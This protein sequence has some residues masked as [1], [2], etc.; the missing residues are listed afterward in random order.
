VHIACGCPSGRDTLTSAC[1]HE[2][3]IKEN[4]EKKEFLQQEQED[5]MFLHLPLQRH[6][7]IEQKSQSP[8]SF[9]RLEWKSIPTKTGSQFTIDY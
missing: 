8:S 5:R 9:D 2:Q 6:A 7:N 4:Y 1:I 3:Y